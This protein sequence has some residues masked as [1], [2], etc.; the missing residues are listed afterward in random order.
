MQLLAP[1]TSLVFVT[2][3]GLHHAAP[4]LGLQGVQGGDQEEGEAPYSVVQQ[5]NVRNVSSKE[6]Y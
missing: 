3:I 4:Q 6:L 5:Y 1:V 2:L